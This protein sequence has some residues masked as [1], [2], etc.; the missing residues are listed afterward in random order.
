MDCILPSTVKCTTSSKG[1]PAINNLPISIPTPTPTLAP[2]SP[3]SSA[4]ASTSAPASASISDSASSSLSEE[5][6]QQTQP[7]NIMPQFSEEDRS[8]IRQLDIEP[9][10][11]AIAKSADPKK[12][13]SFLFTAFVKALIWFPQ[14]LHQSLSRLHSDIQEKQSID[15]DVLSMIS[16][17]VKGSPNSDVWVAWMTVVERYSPAN[18]KTPIRSHIQHSST[19]KHTPMLMKGSGAIVNSSEPRTPMQGVDSELRENL[20]LEVRK[21]EDLL[22]EGIDGLDRY[23]DVVLRKCEQEKA[24]YGNQRWVEW[25]VDSNETDVLKCL[26]TL[27]QIF[28]EQTDNNPMPTSA[29]HFHG[30]PNLRG[31]WSPAP[32]SPGVGIYTR[33]IDDNPLHFADFLVIGELKRNSQ[34][35]NHKTPWLDLSQFVREVFRVQHRRFV[36]GFVICGSQMRVWHFDRSG[37]SGG[38][39]FDVHDY[40]KRF[41][42]VLLA[43]FLMNKT[44]LG[45]D[46]TIKE[47]SATGK[48][49]LEIRRCLTTGDLITERLNLMDPPLAKRAVIVGRATVCWK[50]YLDGDESKAFVVKDSWQYAERPEE[51]ALIKTAA[52]RGVEHFADYYHHET[53]Q[54]D[55]KDDDTLNNVR[56]WDMDADTDLCRR[57]FQENQRFIPPAS[58]LSKQ[59][60]GSVSNSSNSGNHPRSDGQSS[61]PGKS[62]GPVESES[63]SRK[64][65]SRIQTSN[66]SASKRVDRKEG[67][68][69]RVHRRVITRTVGK[70]LTAATTP[71]SIL[72]GFI[73]AIA[74]HE[75]LFHKAGILHRD[76]SLGNI[77]LTEDEKDGFLIDLDFGILTADHTP[78]GGPSRTGTKAFLSLKVLSG[79][80]EHTFMDDLESFFWVFYWLCAHLERPGYYPPKPP[81]SSKDGLDQWNFDSLETLL[82]KKKGIVS[83]D[84]AFPNKIDKYFTNFCRP[85][86]QAAINLR[87]VVFE[88]GLEYKK[89]DRGLYKKMTKVLEAARDALEVENALKAQGLLENSMDVGV[90]GVVG[91]TRKSR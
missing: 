64:R 58:S 38:E 2:A 67:I 44:Q 83:E 88:T 47:D 32:R 68:S 50:A 35:T 81:K 61:R 60:R 10:P 6:S 51:G 63:G 30:H 49:Y 36:L 91:I 57:N 28:H 22:T 29:P 20:L 17:W 53:V 43:F 56:S 59:T 13:W 5:E 89:E 72:N 77:M 7:F 1:S 34:G 78:W 41:V 82:D 80:E 18:P 62:L 69:N 54:V 19:I 84:E 3:S 31:K 40:P 87:R 55:D 65:P 15:E 86:K 71:L 74:G 37:C 24:L 23:T 70:S 9:C 4:S 26:A 21:L 85:L 45:F 12:Q 48:S 52:N 39:P 16:Q 8:R 73:G 33:P 42:R 79:K 76:I 90:K 14:P 11:A 25:P 75:S 46:P 66:Q 27:T